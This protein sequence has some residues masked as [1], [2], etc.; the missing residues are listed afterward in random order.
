MT[1]RP[2]LLTLLALFTLAS[3]PTFAADLNVSDPWIREAPPG[4]SVVAMYM[5]LQ[6]PGDTEQV[7][8]A[9]SSPASD[10]VEI[11]RTLHLDGIASMEQQH[12]VSIPAGGQLA[13]EAGG[14]HIMVINPAPLKAG[15]KV[16]FTLQM[17][18]GSSVVIEAEVRRVMGG[19]PHQH[20]H[21]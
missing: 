13:F 17:Q 4:A 5:L 18:D 6:N 8:T 10:T 16:P 9:V 7:L 12:S 3:A 19:D 1:L 11:H 15:D 2:T 20:H 14:Y 21:H